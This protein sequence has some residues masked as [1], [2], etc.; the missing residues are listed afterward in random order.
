MPRVSRLKLPPV[1]TGPESIG[2]RLARIRKQ[3][4]Y[5]Q[6]ALAEE[7]G[8]I[9]P[10]VSAYEREKIRLNAEMLIRFSKALRVSADE[11]LGLGKN[12]SH[13]TNV[14]V[15]MMQR[16]NKIESLPSAQQRTILRT[17]DLM[18]QAAENTDVEKATS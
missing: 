15:R 6:K 10:L 7:M 11:I 3:K 18:L 8:L 14:S 13:D 9:Q 5:T 12:G 1:N 17:I 4:G 2:Q 16:V